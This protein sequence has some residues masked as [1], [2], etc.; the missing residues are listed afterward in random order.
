MIPPSP[1]CKDRAKMDG[2][3]SFWKHPVKSH[4]LEAAHKFLGSGF[5]RNLFCWTKSG[6]V[7]KCHTFE[8]L[9]LKCLCFGTRGGCLYCGKW[10]TVLLI[11]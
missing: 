2:T 11:V 8:N 10:G 9:P 4:I 7:I 3:P 5:Q 1:V 6:N